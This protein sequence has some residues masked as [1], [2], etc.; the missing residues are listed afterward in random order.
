MHQGGD[1]SVFKCKNK[2]PGNVPGQYKTGLSNCFE[3]DSCIMNKAG[4]S[5]KSKLLFHVHKFF[6]DPKQ[7]VKCGSYTSMA[8]N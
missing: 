3:C 8:V 1:T 7:L 4:L 6:T 5:L 2:S